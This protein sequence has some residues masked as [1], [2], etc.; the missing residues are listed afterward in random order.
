MK[1]ENE[2]IARLDQNHM[3]PSPNDHFKRF[4]GATDVDDLDASIERSP[5]KT[6]II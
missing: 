5:L 1:Y 3:L 4:G 6:V 2:H